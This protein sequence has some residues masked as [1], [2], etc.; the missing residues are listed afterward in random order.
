MPKFV[1]WYSN[2]MKQG[3]K[4]ASSKHVPTVNPGRLV[5]FS[6]NTYSSV[7]ELSSIQI[8][9][10]AAIFDAMNRKKILSF[11]IKN[12]PD[13]STELVLDLPNSAISSQHDAGRIKAE[14]EALRK[15]V[16]QYQYPIAGI[17]ADVSA[18]LVSTVIRHGSSCRVTIP[19]AS[20]P[21]YLCMS[22]GFYNIELGIVRGL[23]SAQ[24][25]RLYI[26]MLSKVNNATKEA[27]K[28]FTLKE[29]AAEIGANTTKVTY[30]ELCK[31]INPL[32]VF[33]KENSRFEMNMSVDY[34]HCIRSGRPA[35]EFIRLK[36]RKKDKDVSDCETYVLNNLNTYISILK[37]KD[38]KI[39]N[40]TQIFADMQERDLIEEYKDKVLK[41]GTDI[42]MYKKANTIKKIL[43]DDFRLDIYNKNA[44]RAVENDNN[45][46]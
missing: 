43:I 38:T 7:K 4:I 33:M 6:R 46:K 3:T 29:L 40:A 35:V 19:V 28:K 30:A 1:I 17:P 16:I 12:V 11:D 42:N 2:K 45:G 26:T 31:I 18:P 15:R 20:L 5:P 23:K 36:V 8:N 32:I 24:Q 21:W 39:I 13:I 44:K 27:V 14:M 41:L 10:M 22:V 25:K 9:G 34:A 37:A